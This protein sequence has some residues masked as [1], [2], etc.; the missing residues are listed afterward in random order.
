MRNFTLT[1]NRLCR[2]AIRIF[3]TYRLFNYNFKNALRNVTILPVPPE[4]YMT[5]NIQLC[6]TP[7]AQKYSK[8]TLHLSKSLKEMFKIDTS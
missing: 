2:S 7:C 4:E 3:Y 6:K 8:S 5:R 1:P